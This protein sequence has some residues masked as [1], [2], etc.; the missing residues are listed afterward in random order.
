MFA[1]IPLPVSEFDPKAEPS[2]LVPIQVILWESLSRLT[3]AHM[4]SLGVWTPALVE[5]ELISMRM[6]LATFGS[7]KVNDPPGLRKNVYCRTL[8]VI[9]GR[10]DAELVSCDW[11]SAPKLERQRH[12]MKK[13]LASLF[14]IILIS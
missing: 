7:E 2:L 1:M 3:S 12:R 6:G 11:A 4:S 13:W 14:D 5:G 10:L 9:G 8:T